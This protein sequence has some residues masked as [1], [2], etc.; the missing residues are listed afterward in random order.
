MILGPSPR[1]MVQWKSALNEDAP[2]IHFHMGGRVLEVWSPAQVGML[3]L[4]RERCILDVWS[5]QK[6]LRWQWNIV[7]QEW[8]CI[9]CWKWGI[10]QCHVNFQGWTTESEFFH[11][12]RI[13]FGLLWFS[14]ADL[15][16]AARRFRARFHQGPSKVPARAR[17]SSTKVLQVS[18]CL[19]F[20]G[21]DPSWAAKR[22]CR[23]FRQGFTEVPPRL[24]KFRDLSG[25]LAQIRFWGHHFSFFFFW[26][27]SPTALALRS[28]AII[29]AL[30]SQVSCGFLMVF[31]VTTAICGGF[32]Q[33]LTAIC[34][35]N[36]CRFIKVL[37][38]VPPP[39]LYIY[40]PVSWDQSCVNCW[41]VSP[42][43]IQSAHN[44]PSSRCC[45]L[46]LWA[47][48]ILES[49]FS[50]K[51][52]NVPDVF[53]GQVETMALEQVAFKS[54]WRQ[55]GR[56]ALIY[57]D[58]NWTHHWSHEQG[59]CISKKN[60][61]TKRSGK[62]RGFEVLNEIF[63]SI[64]HLPGTLWLLLCQMIW[65]LGKKKG[66]TWGP[67]IGWKMWSCGQWHPFQPKMEDHQPCSCQWFL[68]S[69]FMHIL[70]KNNAHTLHR[71]HVQSSS[72]F[73][74]CG[75]YMKLWVP[76][77]SQFFLS[78][79]FLGCIMGLISGTMEEA[80]R[81]KSS[82]AAQLRNDSELGWKSN[83]T[84]DLALR[85]CPMN[86]KPIEGFFYPSKTST[87]KTPWITKHF[88][89]TLRLHCF[90][91]SLI[92]QKLY[93]F[94]RKTKPWSI[95]ISNPFTLLP[96][97]KGW[98]KKFE[99]NSMD[100]HSHTTPIFFWR[101]GEWFFR[102]LWERGV[103]RGRTG[104]SW[105]FFPTNSGSGS[106]NPMLKPWAE[107]SSWL[108][109]PIFFFCSQLD[110]KE[111]E[112]PPWP[113]L[114]L[115]VGEVG[116]GAIFVSEGMEMSHQQKQVWGLKFLPQK[117]SEMWHQGLARSLIHHFLFHIETLF[118]RW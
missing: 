113:G 53:L 61:T 51:L 70:H 27:F 2:I 9:S 69:S 93:L 75:S 42:I 60:S 30:V 110:P 73:W 76:W 59:V 40:L 46:I 71:R 52:Q 37:W 66:L 114:F 90:F 97:R 77:R 21:A 41:H 68:A 33:L 16:W 19:W 50:M 105:K 85:R 82:Q 17:H 103:W 81:V 44:D 25:L 13:A 107:A 29:K 49:F 5:P 116:K 10:F 100:L 62:Q 56:M 84:P 83:L 14:R 79:D 92:F 91:S 24:R 15:S 80:C 22:F 87:N 78:S 38:R 7:H 109:G 26:H 58:S 98:N 65:L 111:L 67:E 12:G 36:G 64:F 112:N 54:S 74:R 99:G 45:W 88:I 117:T 48:S 63:R 43:Q 96:Q 106:I 108:L 57:S 55:S 31:W 23:R 1:I 118:F 4:I 72:F 3:E 104:G 11:R 86:L 18:W 32:C 20:S 6:N 101:M 94:L 35:P 47:F 34:L 95:E 8:S 28:S 39:V 89:R 102:S 115:W